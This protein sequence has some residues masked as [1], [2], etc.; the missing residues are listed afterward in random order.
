MSD[1]PVLA[2]TPLEVKTLLAALR[3][4][5][6]N[7]VFFELSA[8]DLGD[9]GDFAGCRPGRCDRETVSTFRR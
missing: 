1:F 3:S 2:D 4:E 7:R 6:S 5:L 9:L 8:F